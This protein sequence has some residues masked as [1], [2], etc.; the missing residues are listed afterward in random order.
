MPLAAN[1][2]CVICVRWCAQ[3]F[4]LKA[5]TQRKIAQISINRQ[6]RIPEV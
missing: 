6:G 5:Q 3:K 4:Y 2:L 1:L